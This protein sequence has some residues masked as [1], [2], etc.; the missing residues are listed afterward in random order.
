MGSMNPDRRTSGSQR[1]AKDDRALAGVAAPRAASLPVPL[2]EAPEADPHVCPCCASELVYPTGWEPAGA[3]GWRVELRCPNCEWTG[4]GAYNQDQV[5]ELDRVL[6]RG[7]ESLLDDLALLYR[8][9]ME[10]EIEQFTAAL[11][12]NAILPEDFTP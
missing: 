5:D 12:Y 9:T 10:E 11:A 7:T 2:P 8:A 6:D 3:D 1:L 4:A